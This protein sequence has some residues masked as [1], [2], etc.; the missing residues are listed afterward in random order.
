M[1]AVYVETG[2]DFIVAGLGV[3]SARMKYLILKAVVRYAQNAANTW[4]G[5]RKTAALSAGI[6]PQNL[7]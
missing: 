6:T 5:W 2:E 4:M 7:I 1:N 3:S